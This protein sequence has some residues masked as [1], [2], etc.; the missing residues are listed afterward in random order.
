MTSEKFTFSDE[1]QKT[2]KDIEIL[3]VFPNDK[4]ADLPLLV[5]AEDDK[6]VII[7]TY[8]KKMQ[9]YAPDFFKIFDK[10]K[11]KF[12]ESKHEDGSV[13]KT[14]IPGLTDPCSVQKYRGATLFVHLRLGS[15]H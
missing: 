6:K 12:E 11:P 13:Y 14:V 15:L 9:V 4:D 5:I 2:Y 10:K 7:P 8:K 3:H 1:D